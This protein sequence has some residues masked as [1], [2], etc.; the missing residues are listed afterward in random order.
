MNV[1]PDPVRTGNLF[2]HKPTGR[3]TSG[4]EPTKLLGL[5]WPRGGL[6]ATSEMSAH[7]TLM[8]YSRPDDRQLA[9]WQGMFFDVLEFL[10]IM[11]I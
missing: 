5:P 9:S 7:S 10:G 3:L 1:N 8:R 6:V 2:I 4:M 11:Q